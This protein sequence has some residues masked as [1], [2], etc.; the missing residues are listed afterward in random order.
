MLT[1]CFWHSGTH[2]SPPSGQSL[3][4]PAR[5]GLSRLIHFPA[6]LWGQP[7]KKVRKAPLPRQRS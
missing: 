2:A 4:R 7:T 5:R 6:W 3:C 1:R